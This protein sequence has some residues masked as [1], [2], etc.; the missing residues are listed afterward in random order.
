MSRI[1]TA[2]GGGACRLIIT[3]RSTDDIRAL[4]RVRSYSTSLRVPNFPCWPDSRPGLIFKTKYALKHSSKVSQSRK[5]P[6]WKKSIIA[7]SG[8]PRVV[9][10]TRAAAKRLRSFKIKCVCTIEERGHRCWKEH[11]DAPRIRKNMEKCDRISK[12]LNLVV[13]TDWNEIPHQMAWPFRQ[14]RNESTLKLLED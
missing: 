6:C 1:R 2:F 7:H 4:L 3:N 5:Y 9:L 10:F 8:T 13:R 11:L 14:M 12:M